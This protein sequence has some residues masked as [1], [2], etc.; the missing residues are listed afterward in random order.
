MSIRNPA[1]QPVVSEEDLGRILRSEIQDLAPGT[2]LPTVREM[3]QQYGVTL[4]IAQKALQGLKADG[5]ATTHVGRGTFV[6]G[7]RNSRLAGADPEPST[8]K[9]DGLRVLTLH[10]L[11]ASHRGDVIAHALHDRLQQDGHRSI[12][13][14]YGDVAT[15][16]QLLGRGEFDFCVIQPRRSVLPVRLLDLIRTRARHVV[17]EGRILENLDVDVVVR[18]RRASVAIALDHLLELGHR[19]LMLLTEDPSDAVG[20]SEIEGLFRLWQQ[21]SGIGED[22]SVCHLPPAD[23]D[24]GAGYGDLTSQLQGTKPDARP[25]AM[26]VSG[27]FDEATLRAAI[28]NAGLKIPDDLSVVYLR[29]A[30]SDGDDAD[31]FT[32]VSRSAEQVVTTLQEH[33]AWRA[34]NPKA[35]PRT[36]FD[37]PTLTVRGSSKAPNEQP[38]G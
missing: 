15:L 4:H 33:I 36:L 12:S 9:P 24:N 1:A 7:E 37:R 13:V 21:A 34:A 31:G 2:R 27:R 32:T 35:P 26:L 5:L 18:D 14:A 19:R 8:D 16:E 17:V 25:T 11:T 10:H 6:S 38:S 23:A 28:Q 20:Y 30:S 22:W 29:S 3:M